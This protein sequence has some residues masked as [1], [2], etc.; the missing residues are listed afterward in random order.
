[1]YS[2]VQ[3][4]PGLVVPLLQA[5]A[6]LGFQAVLSDPAEVW[7]SSLKWVQSRIPAKHKLQRWRERAGPGKC[8]GGVSLPTLELGHLQKHS[9]PMPL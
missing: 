2:A 4:G 7:F 9:L 8:E 5:P 6:Q 1:M 3:A